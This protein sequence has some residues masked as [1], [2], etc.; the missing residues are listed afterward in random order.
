MAGDRTDAILRAFAFR[1]AV[2]SDHLAVAE[3]LPYLRGRAREDLLD[4]M[5]AGARDAGV[6]DV[7]VHEDELHALRGML[8]ASG[9]GDVISVTALGMRPEIFAW[10]RRRGA[11]RSSPADLKRLVKRA[12]AGAGRAGFSRAT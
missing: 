3:L 1:A 5:R 8:R 11:Q 4:Q 9:P 6:L 10:L 12:R 7:A 2:G